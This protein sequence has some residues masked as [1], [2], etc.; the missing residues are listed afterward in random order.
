MNFFETVYDLV[1][2]TYHEKYKPLGAFFID[3]KI[4]PNKN[5]RESLGTHYQKKKKATKLTVIVDSTGIPVS[6]HLAGSNVHDAS[7]TVL[8]I[9]NIRIR[10]PKRVVGDKGY[11]SQRTKDKLKRQHR[12]GLIYPHRVNQRERSTP[13][14]KKM[15]KKRYIVENYFAWLSN[16]GRAEKRRDVFDATFM[17]FLMF[18]SLSMIITRLK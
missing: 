6:F 2:L 13:F 12:I 15:L 5:G 9:D 10:K 1:L 7:L 11:I 3:A 14:E 17:A 8:A 4:I 18:A 16:Y